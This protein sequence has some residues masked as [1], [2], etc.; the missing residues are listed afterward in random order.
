MAKFVESRRTWDKGDWGNLG[1]Y[2]A[3]AGG[4]GF[5]KAEN[6]VVYNDGSIGPRPGLS[7]LAHTGV[8]SGLIRMF[9]YVAAEV[10]GTSGVI[11]FVV[12][13]TAYWV[14]AF[15]AGAATSIGTL[16]GTETEFCSARPVLS[17][18]VVYFATRNQ[19]TYK[20]DIG[21][22]TLTQTSTISGIYDLERYRDR[23]Y[24]STT[25]RIYY[26]DAANFSTWTTAT[27]FFDVG[28]QFDNYRL[29]SLRN[30]LFVITQGGGH[31]IVSGVP[32]STLT[33]REAGVGISP[34]EHS[35]VKVPAQDSVWW[36][37]QNRNAPVKFRGGIIDV[38]SL[39][40]LE[41]WTDSTSGFRTSAFSYGDRA[42]IF[43]GTI[44]NKALLHHNDIW[45]RHAFAVDAQL[46]D[47]AA[48]DYFVFT[49]AGTSTTAAKFWLW[50]YDY[51]QPGLATEVGA[52]PGDN[53]DTPLSAHVYLP[54]W[55]HPQGQDVRAESVEVEF[56]SYDTN[57]A[58]TAHFD[59]VVRAM[60]PKVVG[61]A[62]TTAY[63]DSGTYDFDES[64]ASS[65][66][67]GTERREVF[68]IGD[69]G[70]ARGYQIRFSNV[71]NVAIRSVTLTAQ[72]ESRG[73][74]G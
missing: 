43:V 19:G 46:V 21:A 33:L 28:W 13:N 20:W 72:A 42:T 34:D 47:R 5:F 29:A 22:G 27:S 54:E 53:S 62:A 48:A 68:H 25:R 4:D 36:I 1:S 10:S 55:W 61:D 30:N 26:T 7:Q 67:G 64:T 35:A 11:L 57:T 52:Q 8:P 16:A 40:H 41:D 51:G 18:G 2:R 45:T 37:P 14:P 73:G 63:V 69:Q 31:Y 3:G 70:W 24:A 15:T 17:E 6:M 60:R 56:V 59:M 38:D 66:A 32:E 12:G 9:G 23:L 39:A 49:D 71:R 65:A 50:E 44:D 58:A 74:R